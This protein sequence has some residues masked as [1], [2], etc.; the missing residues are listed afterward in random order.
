MDGSEDRRIAP[1]Q[2][3]GWLL[4]IRHART[5]F[6]LI[7]PPLV[8]VL[9][10]GA[11]PLILLTP[12]LQTQYAAGTIGGLLVALGGLLGLRGRRS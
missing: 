8:A 10:V 3:P 9:T 2:E 11:V 5:A 12:A 7:F 6:D 4:R 1:P